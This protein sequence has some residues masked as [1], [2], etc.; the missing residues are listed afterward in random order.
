MAA[1]LICKSN[2]NK[3]WILIKYGMDKNYE[4]GILRIKMSNINNISQL[5]SL[6]YFKLI[7]QHKIQ[8]LYVL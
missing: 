5:Y 2:F 7:L 3:G 8:Y 6:I 1:P 4:I